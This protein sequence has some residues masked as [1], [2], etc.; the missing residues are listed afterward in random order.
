MKR[1]VY[2]LRVEYG[3]GSGVEDR[4]AYISITGEKL[5]DVISLIHQDFPTAERVTLF[6][7][8]VI[9]ETVYETVIYGEVSSLMG[10]S[11]TAEIEKL[12]ANGEL[13]VGYPARYVKE[14]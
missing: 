5:L 14:S 12:R 7:I 4:T 3:A 8:T 10:P 13:S 1:K 9:D 6:K 2:F 11:N